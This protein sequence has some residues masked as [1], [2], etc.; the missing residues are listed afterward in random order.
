MKQGLELLAQGNNVAMQITFY[1]LV[2]LYIVTYSPCNIH[3][4]VQALSV[5]SKYQNIYSFAY[6]DHVNFAICSLSHLCVLISNA[7]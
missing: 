5:L 7:I 6:G 1:G 3:L 2:V 4:L